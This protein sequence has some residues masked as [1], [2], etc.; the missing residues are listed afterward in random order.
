MKT[1]ITRLLVSAIKAKAVEISEN[2]YDTEKTQL[3]NS[4][5]CDLIFSSKTGEIEADNPFIREWLF[6][7]ESDIKDS[8]RGN[9]VLWRDL[10][11]FY[12]DAGFASPFDKKQFPL[13]K[14]HEMGGKQSLIW[15]HIGNTEYTFNSCQKN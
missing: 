1:P 8:Q 9:T 11:R 15:F 13:S 14:L 4:A 6:Q 5:L 12:V 10:K 7:I 2:T 3:L